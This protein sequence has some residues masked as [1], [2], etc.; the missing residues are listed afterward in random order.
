MS[1]AHPPRRIAREER[2]IAEMIALYCRDHHGD[3]AAREV[4][5]YGGPR[6]IRAHPVLA[7]AHLVDGRRTPGEN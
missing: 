6:M 4:M 1:D 2:T 7:V 5:R 3:E